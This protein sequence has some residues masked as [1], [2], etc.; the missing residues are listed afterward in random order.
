MRWTTKGDHDGAVA[1]ALRDDPEGLAGAA[2]AFNDRMDG[3]DHRLRGAVQGRGRRCHGSGSEVAVL[4]L[5]AALALAVA[6][7]V[8]GVQPRI[9][10]YR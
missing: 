10:E 5:A 7:V 2:A 1:V 4:A 6:C 9:G 8:A 3:V